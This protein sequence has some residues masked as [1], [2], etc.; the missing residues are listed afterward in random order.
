MHEDFKIHEADHF[1]TQLREAGSRQTFR[2][3]LSA[4]LSAARSALQY[5]LKEAK[6]KPGGKAWYGQ[7]VAIDPVVAFLRDRRD[8]NIHEQPAPINTNVSMILSA[9]LSMSATIS[10]VVTDGGLGDRRAGRQESGQ[11]R[12]RTLS[13][14]LQNS[15]AAVQPL[16]RFRRGTA[17]PAR[18]PPRPS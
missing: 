4:F 7:Q 11:G 17:A 3:E 15:E 8:T 13:D 10:T 9:G 1:L 6:A 2:F 12:L 5:A 18:H 16:S 14:V